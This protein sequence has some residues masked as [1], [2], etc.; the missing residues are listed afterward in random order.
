MNF[1]QACYRCAANRVKW[2]HGEVDD[3]ALAIRENDVGLRLDR[4]GAAGMRH[5]GDRV[6]SRVDGSN[7]A[8]R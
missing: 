5:G 2:S 6:A 4:A 7:R 3:G 8:D 1:L